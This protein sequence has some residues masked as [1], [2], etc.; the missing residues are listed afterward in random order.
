MH[1][2]ALDL[3]RQQVQVRTDADA[4]G[5]VATFLAL[6]AAVWGSVGLPVSWDSSCTQAL[7]PIASM[8]A[9]S[10]FQQPLSSP[11]PRPFLPYESWREVDDDDARVAP[12][13]FSPAP[14]NY[15]SLCC[16]PSSCGGGDAAAA[17]HTEASCPCGVRAVHIPLAE[18]AVES[19]SD[20][21]GAGGAAASPAWSASKGKRKK[22][23]KGIGKR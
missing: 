6:K 16:A 10:L 2:S 5:V 20:S 14:V 23:S 13:H 19:G 3:V 18:E 1:D 21:E 7:A 22:K 9:P 15:F 8:G 4:Q 17:L 11:L 12:P